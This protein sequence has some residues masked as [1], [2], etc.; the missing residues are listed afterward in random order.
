MRLAFRPLHAL[1]MAS[2]SP[3]E[4]SPEPNGDTKRILLQRHGTVFA[5]R[6]LG[7]EGP[8]GGRDVQFKRATR[9]GFDWCLGSEIRELRRR[10][11]AGLLGAYQSQRARKS[12]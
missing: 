7:R 11:T 3:P 10:G 2:P 4:H 12:R 6:S 1:A 8:I 9:G 5:V